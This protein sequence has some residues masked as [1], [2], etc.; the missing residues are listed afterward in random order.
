MNLCAQEKNFNIDNIHSLWQI[1]YYWDSNS[2]TPD[3][4][5]V[6]IIDSVGCKLFFYSYF[7]LGLPLKEFKDRARLVLRDDIGPSLLDTLKKYI[8]T[9]NINDTIYRNK[10]LSIMGWNYKR[11]AILYFKN[12]TKKIYLDNNKEHWNLF[13]LKLVETEGKYKR[14]YFELIK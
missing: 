2:D 12:Y 8:T 13:C 11:W 4:E 1:V 5:G 6:L 14:K 3:Y 7:D 9:E 10:D